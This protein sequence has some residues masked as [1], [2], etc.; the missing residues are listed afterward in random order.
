MSGASPGPPAATSSALDDAQ[1]RSQIK[2]AWAQVAGTAVST[3][4]VIL[5]VVV[6]CQSQQTVNHNSQVT[7]QQS[8]DSQLSTAVTALGSGNTAERVAGLQL[9]EQNV[10]GRITL[11]SK[12]GEPPADVFSNYQTALRIFSGYLSSQGQDFLT[13]ISNTPKTVPFGRGYGTPSPP[14]LPI[15]ISYAA[16]QMKYLLALNNSTFAV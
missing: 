5:A 7:L 1:K 10:L 9:L 16:D 11:S 6:A 3:A 13:A 12:T 2:A 4:A 8:E 14:G 15:D